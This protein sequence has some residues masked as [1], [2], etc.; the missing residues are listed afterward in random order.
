MYVVQL[1]GI[2]KKTQSNSEQVIALLYFLKDKVLSSVLF[3]RPPWQV[4]SSNFQALLTKQLFLFLFVCFDVLPPLS[5]FVLK[6]GIISRYLRYR[7]D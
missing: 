3:F 4:F 2:V 1:T 5:K 6:S 7:H